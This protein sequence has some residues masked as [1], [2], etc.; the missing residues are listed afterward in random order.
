[1][2]N[3]ITISAAESRLDLR[4]QDAPAQTR[5]TAND[6]QDVLGPFRG[7][8]IGALLGSAMWALLLI[9]AVMIW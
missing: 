9:A 4:R 7:I 3:S 5:S 2:N 1:M 8:L 6:K